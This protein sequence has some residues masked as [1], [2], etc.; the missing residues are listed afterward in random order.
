MFQISEASKSGIQQDRLL[1]IEHRELLDRRSSSV[2]SLRSGLLASSSTGYAWGYMWRRSSTLEHSPG[3]RNDDIHEKLKEFMLACGLENF[4]GYM[5]GF[6]NSPN[7]VTKPG[8]TH[9]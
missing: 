6:A 2:C 1:K 5:G 4:G 9:A 8:Y 7:K 3:R